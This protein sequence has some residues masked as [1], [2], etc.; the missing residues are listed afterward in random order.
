[1]D[2]NAQHLVMARQAAGMGAVMV[3]FVVSRLRK[4]AGDE[5]IPYGPRTHTERHRQSTLQMMYNYND[6]ECIAMLHMRRVSFFHYATCLEVEALY[7]RLL[8]AQLRSK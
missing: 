1:M 5:S 4:I 8:D 6:T 7:L 2:R 3:C